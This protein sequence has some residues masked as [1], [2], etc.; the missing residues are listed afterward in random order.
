MGEGALMRPD[1]DYEPEEG[2]ERRPRP[3]I[4]ETGTWVPPKRCRSRSG[5]YREKHAWDK[6]GVCV[7][8]DKGKGGKMKSSADIRRTAGIL[9]RTAILTPAHQWLAKHA[10]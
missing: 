1:Y 5:V 7:F 4:I 8:C 2:L 10:R 9:K 6:D 3:Q